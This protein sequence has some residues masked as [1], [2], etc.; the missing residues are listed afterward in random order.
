[1]RTACRKGLRQLFTR[2]LGAVAFFR[3]KF[4]SVDA[5]LREALL[6]P[7]GLSG[8]GRS[9]RFFRTGSYSKRTT[10]LLTDLLADIIVSLP[11]CYFSYGRF[12]FVSL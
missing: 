3:E 5:V 12:S 10:C 9:Q 6:K 2:V 8:G 1:M 4:G 7:K 11:V